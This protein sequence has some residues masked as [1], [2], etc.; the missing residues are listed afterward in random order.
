[1]CLFEKENSNHDAHGKYHSTNKIRQKEREP[2]EKRASGENS[3][4]VIARLSKSSPKGWSYNG[5]AKLS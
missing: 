4:I 2:I 5:P 3:W 1:M